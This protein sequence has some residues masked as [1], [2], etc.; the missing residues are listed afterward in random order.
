LE[1]EVVEI[2]VNDLGFWMDLDS[3]KT[4]T[5][6]VSNVNG[7][8]GNDEYLQNS[9][10]QVKFN[11]PEVINGP[12]FIWLTTNNKAIENSYKLIDGAGNIIFQR[13]QLTNQTQYKDTFNLAPGCYSVII[14]DT[15]NDGLSFWYSSQVEG[16]TAGQMR[17]RYVGGSYIEIFP[18]DFGRYHRYDF[19][20]GFGVGL[21][22]QKL[23]HEI[24]VFP[25]PGSDEITIEISGFVD[26]EATLEIYDVMGKKW[27]TETMNA[28][29]TFAE[30]QVSISHLP[31]G[32]YVARIVT[33]NQVYTKKFIKK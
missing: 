30:S 12:F 24:A 5:A 9:V 2:P 20:V 19:S 7:T 25:N 15:D 21:N 1:E 3:T 27:H 16:E 23:D 6:Y 28:S 4:F 8:F 10:K 14:E 26:H 11:A 17:L 29:A 13:N 33:K 31:V 18:G 32:A 22:E